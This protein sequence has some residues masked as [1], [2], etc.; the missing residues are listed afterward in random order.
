M[1]AWS[2]AGWFLAP[3]ECLLSPMF[4]RRPCPE[5]FE[6]WTRPR[7]KTQGCTEL[8]DTHY[9]SYTRSLSVYDP[10]FSHI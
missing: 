9:K 4:R 8:N 7:G 1:E 3:E 10:C 2:K 6:L 5:I